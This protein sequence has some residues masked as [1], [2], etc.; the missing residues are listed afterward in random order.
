MIPAKGDRP[1]SAPVIT[2]A[3]VLLN[4]LE[5]S[6]CQSPPGSAKAETEG[7]R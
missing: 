3:S 6:F 1:G 7:S 2:G 5:S 4:L